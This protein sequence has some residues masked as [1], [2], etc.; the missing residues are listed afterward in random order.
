MR[1]APLLFFSF[2]A[3]VVLGCGFVQ[4]T[5]TGGDTSAATS[6][7]GGTDAATTPTGIVGGGCG[8]EANSGTEL[9]VATSACPNVVVD[10]TAFPNCGFRIVSGASELVCA[11]DT[12]ICSMGAFTTCDQAAAL[13]TSQTQEQVCLQINEGRCSAA[14]PVP[15]SSGSSGSSGSTCDKQCLSECGGGEACAS[16]CGC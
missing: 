14:I 5:P 11:C 1:L 13:L 10:T 2:G 16:I 3:L 15:S 9:C 4:L 8:I 6:A 7:E 12:Q